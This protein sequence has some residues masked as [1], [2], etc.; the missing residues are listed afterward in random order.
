MKKCYTVIK[1][2]CVIACI[3]QEHR[4]C[5]GTT[6]HLFFQAN[7]RLSCCN[8]AEVMTTMMDDTTAVDST[9]ASTVTAGKLHLVPVNIKMQICIDD[10]IQSNYSEN[11][12]YSFQYFPSCFQMIHF[13]I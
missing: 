3:M 11:Y 2:V 1:I 8:I 12:H 10:G 7:K 13:C 6:L 4:T 5:T 9:P